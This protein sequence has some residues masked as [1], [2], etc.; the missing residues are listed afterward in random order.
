[1]NLPG[2]DHL[3]Y[4]SAEG[5]ITSK[6]I[7]NKQGVDWVYLAQ[8]RYQRRALVNTVMKLQSPTEDGEFD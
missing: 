3:E 4:L 1:M 5:R 8:G 7:L 6:R 2:R